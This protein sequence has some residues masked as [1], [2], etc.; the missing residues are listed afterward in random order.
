MFLWPLFSHS[1]MLF[2]NTVLSK[3]DR[4]L[5]FQNRHFS[6]QEHNLLYI[7][8]IKQLLREAMDDSHQ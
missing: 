3:R 5:F 2:H 4:S 8:L 6:L 7:T 1:R